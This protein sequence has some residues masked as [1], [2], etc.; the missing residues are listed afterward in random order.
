MLDAGFAIVTKV[1]PGHERAVAAEVIG[2]VRGR[3]VVIGDDMIVSG[4]NAPRRSGRAA[5]GRHEGRACVRDTRSPHAGCRRD[6]RR[7]RHRRARGHRHV[8]L[9]D[10]SVSP[11]L[12]VVT[13]AG[14]LAETIRAVFDSGSV[15][16]V[17][18]GE[19]ELF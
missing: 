14:M 11:G 3:H 18:A 6:A 4:G 19:N 17:L 15:S 9:D 16:S 8:A 12:V 7:G 5:G 1:R 10:A 13:T 2:D